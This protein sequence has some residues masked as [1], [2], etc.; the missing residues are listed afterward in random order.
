MIQ[1]RHARE[2]DAQAIAEVYIE[3]WQCTYAG[4]LPDQVLIGMNPQKLML[5]FA[6]ALKN[7]KEII[8]LRGMR[9]KR[10]V[11]CTWCGRKQVVMLLYRRYYF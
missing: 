7:H 9:L 8:N 10:L 2:I 5:S 1:I 6:R 4:T 3:T 11:A